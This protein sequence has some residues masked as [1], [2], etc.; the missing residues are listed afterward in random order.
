MRTIVVTNQKGGIGKTTTALALSSLLH[1]SGH[2]TL[3][4]DADP[5]GNASDTFRAGIQWTHTLYDVLLER[6]PCTAGDAIQSTH[7]GDIIAS[8]PLLRKADEVLAG[9]VNGLYRLSDA[10]DSLSDKYDYVVI[11]TAPAINTLLYNCLIAADEVIVP[12]SADRYSILG[13]SQ[14]YETIS[15]IKKRQNQNLELAGLLLVKYGGRTNLSRDA[16][17][18]LANTAEKLNTRLFT[19]AIREC[20]K[21]QEAQAQRVSLFDYAPRCTTVQ[22]YEEFY[23]EYTG[24]QN[25]G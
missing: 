5:Q 10:L 25:N 22:D 23:R 7:T 2:R 1:R 20:V 8:D 11:D 12:V 18:V 6:E 3:L 4:I 21:C 15:A 14:L 24:G 17:E 9:D 19:T 16:K 13:L